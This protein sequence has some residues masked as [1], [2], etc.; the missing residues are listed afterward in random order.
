MI[1]HSLNSNNKPCKYNFLKRGTVKS[2]SWV[3]K[4]KVN[5][6]V[7]LFNIVVLAQFRLNNRSS[8]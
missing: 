1:K 7:C 6:K 3:S 8:L 4:R 2:K 5:V